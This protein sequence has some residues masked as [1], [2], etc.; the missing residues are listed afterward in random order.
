MQFRRQ[1]NDIGFF[2]TKFSIKLIVIACNYID[3]YDNNDNNNN[4]NNNDNKNDN[5]NDNNNNSNKNDKDDHNCCYS[6]TEFKIHIVMILSK[7]D[8]N[9]C[10]T[11]TAPF[12]QK[13]KK[14]KK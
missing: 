1:Y 9:N 3:C 7:F 11:V 4:N 12:N 8:S 14:L 10:F 13:I 5:N 6:S 2:F